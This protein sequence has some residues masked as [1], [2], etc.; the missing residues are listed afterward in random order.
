[1][2]DRYIFYRVVGQTDQVVVLK[3][4]GLKQLLLE[5]LHAR[6]LVRHLGAQKTLLCRK[7]FDGLGLLRL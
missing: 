5:E 3:N 4:R 1:M 2:K 6:T 7:L